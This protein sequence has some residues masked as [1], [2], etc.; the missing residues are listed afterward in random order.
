[1]SIHEQMAASHEVPYEQQIALLHIGV[2]IDKV[3][4]TAPLDEWNAVY[5]RNYGSSGELIEIATSR[6]TL[7]TQLSV[8]RTAWP[9]EKPCDYGIFDI[10][11]N[12]GMGGVG[13]RLEWNGADLQ[14][15]C[16][17]MR[18]AIEADTWLSAKELNGIRPYLEYCFGA[19]AER[20]KRP[21]LPEPKIEQDGLEPSND[22]YTARVVNASHV[23]RFQLLASQLRASAANKTEAAII[24]VALQASLDREV[25][26]PLP[27]SL[28][29]LAQLA[30][31]RSM[32]QPP[33]AA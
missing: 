10:D 1:M 24:E 17:V 13:G 16:N 7:G 9:G 31:R 32:R 19:S 30:I 8:M 6:L 28:E 15:A 11:S 20:S 5:E 21:F 26:A 14:P 29:I 18:G 27:G 23:L 25:G 22:A 4:Q 3:M 2:Y 33:R 12:I